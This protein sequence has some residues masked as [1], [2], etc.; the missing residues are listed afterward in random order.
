MKPI[1]SGTVIAILAIIIMAIVSIAMAYGIAQVLVW[2][3]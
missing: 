2:I 3:F 1:I